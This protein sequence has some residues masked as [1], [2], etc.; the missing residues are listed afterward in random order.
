MD[1]QN[2]TISSDNFGFAAEAISNAAT[3]S[4]TIV[5]G[6]NASQSSLT[7][8]KKYYVQ[9]DGSLNTIA[10]NPSLFAGTAISA[11]ELIVKR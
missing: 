8:G 11:T 9:K 5:T 10:D 2:T 1:I 3:G 7:A 6:I 4:I